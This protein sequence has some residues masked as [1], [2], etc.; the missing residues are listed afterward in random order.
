MR[1]DFF[2]RISVLPGLGEEVERALY[3]LRPMSL[4]GLREAIVAPARAGGVSFESDVL[5]RHLVDSTA[6]GAGSL[7]LLSFALTELWELRD[8]PRARITQAALDALGGVAGVLSRHADGVVAR[9]SAPETKEARRLLIRL[10]TADRTGMELGEDE[11]RLD[12]RPFALNFDAVAHEMGHL[13]LFGI[14]G[15]PGRPTRDFFAYHESVG[16]FLSLIGLLQFDTALDRV[17]A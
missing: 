17:L 15:A 12:L 2:T 11:S 6:H 8:V 1:G 14:V 10:T 7:P 4:E 16:D 3:L 13:I 5:V 9:L